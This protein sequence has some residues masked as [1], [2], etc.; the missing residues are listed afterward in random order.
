MFRDGEPQTLT[1]SQILRT[2]YDA[3]NFDAMSDDQCF[4]WSVDHHS[5]TQR[6]LMSFNACVVY[7]EATTFTY[8]KMNGYFQNH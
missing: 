6:P 2:L 3:T 8:K 5:D 4:A 7:T 1:W